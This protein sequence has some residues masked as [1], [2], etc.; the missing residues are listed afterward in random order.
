M[1]I[2]YLID[3]NCPYSYIGLNRIKNACSELDLDVEWEM[4]P[5]E[6]EPEA[7][8]RPTISITERYADKYFNTP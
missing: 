8:K 6:L 5:F 1:R 2:I 3:F 4:K 7:G